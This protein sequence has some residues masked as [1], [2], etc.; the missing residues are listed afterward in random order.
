M[1]MFPQLHGC[2]T[3]KARKVNQTSASFVAKIPKAAE[4][5]GDA[6]DAT[7]SSIIEGSYL[8]KVNKAVMV[9]IPY[10]VGAANTTF[11]IQVIGWTVVD[12]GKSTQEWIPVELCELLCTLGTMT[13]IAGGAVLD[14][15]NFADTITL[16]FGNDNVSV[17]RS[18][19]ANNGVGHAV[20]S[21]KSFAKFELSFQT[22]SSATSCNA[23][24]RTEGF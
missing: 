9:L 24:I 17:D 10:G 16:T 1:S 5:I 14:T 12:Q 22:G 11:S 15:E 20:V 23:L 13:G 21:L 19:P 8:S 4:P 2:P 3:T 6:G 7:G 18:S